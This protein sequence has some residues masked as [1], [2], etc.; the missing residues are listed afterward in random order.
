[1]HARRAPLALGLTLLLLVAQACRL[2]DLEEE[3]AKA[4]ALPQTSFL[5]AADR[6]L[7]TALHAG[8]NRVVVPSSRIPE[9]V[10]NAVVAVEDKRFY[11]HKGIDLKAV[12][13]AA[14][15]DATSGR[16]VEGGSTITQQYVKN[17][18]V[19][20]EQ[21]LSRK[22]K[23]A[24]LAWQL[25]HTLSKNQILTKYLNTVYFGGGAYGIQA[26]AETFFDRPATEL[27]LAQSALLAGLVSAPVDYDPIAHPKR[28][29]NRRYD[30][31]EQMLEQEMIGPAAFKRA[32]FTEIRLH[33]PTERAQRYMAPYFVDYFEQWFLRNPRFGTSQAERY[34]LLFEG[35]LRI[36]TTLEPRLQRYAEEAVRE[37]LAYGSD[38]YAAM[39]VIDPRTGY[40]KAM[41][42]GRDYFDPEDRFA[43]L[44]LATGGSTG[45]QAGSA[46][47]Q[48]ALVA[49]L[50]N[51]ISPQ[52]VYPAPGSL[53]IPLE[54]GQ[55]WNVQ[56]Y[57]GSSSGSL[58]VE[59]A[60]INSV[61]TVYAQIIMDVGPQA[62]ID[63]AKKM[64]IR[65]C[66]RTTEPK[67]D[68]QAFPSAVLGANEVNTMEMASGFGTLATGGQH[69]QPVPV[70]RILTAD[71]EVLFDAEA[72]RNPR[73]VV[74][75][76][77]A[78]VAAG[79][80]QKVVLYG[81]GTAANIGRP[82]IGKTGT[83]QQWRDAWFV[84]AIPQLTA[85]VWVG[86]PQGQISMIAPTTR[87]YH[88]LGGTWPAQIWR[89]F[90][91]KATAHMPVRQ[92][93]SPEIEYVTARV[94]IT[95]GCL[96]NPYTPPGNIRT[97]QFIA[98]TEPTKVCEEPSSYQ[99]LTVPSLIGLK[100]DRAAQVLQSSGFNVDVVYAES[101]Q[102][103]GTVIAQDPA[104]GEQLQQTST[105]TITVAKP[106][107]SPSP[108][109][110][111]VPDVI[112]LTQESATATLEQA[113]FRVAVVQDEECNPN[114][115]PCDYQSGL[116]WQQSPD[117]GTE[118][119]EGDTVTIWVNP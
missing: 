88:V 67:T 38:P 70:M 102:K 30:V 48:F 111:V 47:K 71:G 49:A 11:D 27:T 68:L 119:S 106:E 86:F 87:I 105:V 101:S 34:N 54:G 8:E 7:I 5:Y 80:L 55:V 99:L 20:T 13:R 73:Q 10:R 56:N 29:L 61:N 94:D 103:A 4:P 92:F 81:T 53:T 98:G 113:G 84:G 100:E 12:L 62:V 64:G 3:Q 28:A 9:T 59:S 25:E 52:S 107:S 58:T 116:V 36:Y 6:S 104:A 46:F 91:V 42:G 76:A 21:T 85:A 66:R 110:V 118:A 44:N 16:I 90:M 17:T 82:Q 43:K 112:G 51:G 40:V 45:R 109:V 114:A 79:I 31:L 117:G 74:D 57:D 15:V 32:S 115:P 75:P 39:T 50:E 23:E 33:L 65:C 77:V 1:M 96:A 2:P 78:S 72:E 93:P 35:G 14:Y 95:Q 19:G 37:V 63:V 60:T 24:Y 89:A 69:V 108:S 22:I 26:A 83:A 41:V 97:L 18:M